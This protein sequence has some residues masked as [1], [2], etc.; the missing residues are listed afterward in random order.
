MPGLP[1]PSGV[2]SAARRLYAWVADLNYR[3][4]VR[5][6]KK[7][8][9]GVDYRSYEPL[10]LRKNDRLLKLMIERCED[11]EAVY[12]VGANVGDYG[13]ALA[14]TYDLDV[15]A[16]EPHPETY[17]K[18]R[19]NV[20]LNM[21]DDQISTYQVG[22]SDHEGETTLYVASPHH[23]RSS[24]NREKAETDVSSVVGSV[25]VPVATLDSIVGR[26]EIQ[27]P[28]HLKID[29]EGHGLNVLRGA[30][31]TLLR[32]RPVVY[33]EHHGTH[34]DEIRDLFDR[35]YYSVETHGYPWICLPR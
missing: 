9:F 35:L 34:T 29:V 12:D 11:G 3:Y 31:Q 7:R 15:H 28:D 33:F 26:Q 10:N 1:E 25:E 32:H 21:L 17:M 4:E 2:P 6:T 19:K 13:L 24:F 30:E 27:P 5:P 16:F 22:L 20:D 14:S 23:G 18:L 8:V